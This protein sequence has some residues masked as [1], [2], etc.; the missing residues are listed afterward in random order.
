MVV[1]VIEAVQ[2]GCF[3]HWAACIRLVAPR[4]RPGGTLLK[5]TGWSTSSKSSMSSS[6]SSSKLGPVTPKMESIE[7]K[8]MVIHNY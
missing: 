5:F 3:C 7:P 8:I 6:T 2:A 4:P 1:V